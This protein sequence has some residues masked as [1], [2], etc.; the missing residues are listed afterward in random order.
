M[1]PRWLNSENLIT[2]N[3][4]WATNFKRKE[5][6]IIV[7]NRRIEPFTKKHNIFPFKFSLETR[8]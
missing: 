6:I 2:F 4:Q 7:K 8:L 5:I 3:A 1:R